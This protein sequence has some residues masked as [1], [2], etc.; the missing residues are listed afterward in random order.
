MA[1]F[2]SLRSAFKMVADHAQVADADHAGGAKLKLIEA[3]LDSLMEHGMEGCS[4]RRISDRAG[5][6]TGL[7]NYHFSSIHQLVADAYSHL[8]STFLD[9]AIEASS[10]HEAKPRQQASVFLQEIFAS[11]VMRRRVLRAWVVFWGL[12]DSAPPIK[13]AHEASNNSFCR[14]LESLFKKMDAERAVKPSPRLAAIGLS[15]MIDGLWLEWCLQSDE[16]SRQEC[17]R[18]CELWVDTV[19]PEK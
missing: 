8:A 10:I 7:I 16:F 17:I 15:A 19:W 12:I 1:T 9:K 4:V 11:R 13:A 2:N 5:V 18:V 14:F 3:T 6:S